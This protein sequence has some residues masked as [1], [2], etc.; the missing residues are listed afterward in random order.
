MGSTH[1]STAIPAPADWRE[2]FSDWDSIRQGYPY[3]DE[4]E[5]VRDCVRRLGA[6]EPDLVPFWTLGLLMLAPQVAFGGP[7]PGVE[8]EFVAALRPLAHRDDDGSCTHGWH[9]YDIDVD[10][11]LEQLP[12]ILEALT[13]PPPLD[14]LLPRELVPERCLEEGADGESE[15]VSLSAPDLL[16][17]W[18]CPRTAPGFARAALDYVFATVD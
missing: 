3:V 4:D 16:A 2:L 7:G 6:A 9:P 13:S 5:A 12:E 17:R 14:G 8:D 18:Q 11:L 1:T 10:E 15:P